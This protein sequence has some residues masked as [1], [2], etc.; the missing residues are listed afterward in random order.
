LT[1]NQDEGKCR[2]PT[3]ATDTEFAVKGPDGASLASAGR[4]AWW[5]VDL[6]SVIVHEV[7]NAL[8]LKK[9][10]G[11]TQQVTAFQILTSV[12]R[13]PLP[14]QCGASDPPSDFLVAPVTESSPPRATPVAIPPQAGA[15][16]VQLRNASARP[17]QVVRGGNSV[18]P[19][20][21]IDPKA[22]GEI[23]ADADAFEFLFGAGVSSR[24][25]RGQIRRPAGTLS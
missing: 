1:S 17:G 21:P 18:L 5:H 23:F 7:G 3:P 4:P 13:S 2:D 14:G 20:S 10:Q 9:P 11:G 22:V 12:R 24:L 8:G 6:L 16:G 19:S 25:G 15:A